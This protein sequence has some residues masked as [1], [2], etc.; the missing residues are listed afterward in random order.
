VATVGGQYGKGTVFKLTRTPAGTWHFE[1]LYAFKGTPDGA[2][3]YGALVFDVAGR[4]FGTAYYE[5]AHGYG[6]VF[7][8]A[9]TPSGQW[10]E[11]VIHSFAG[12]WQGGYPSGHLNLIDGELYGT[13]SEGGDDNCYCGTIFKL[14]DLGE[15]QWYHSVLHIF[16]GSP[17]G[18]SAYN[19]M[20]KG[21][22]GKLYGATVHGG[23]DDDGVVFKFTP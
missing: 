11:R 23:A 17:D 15:S 3:P 19:G 9:R 14:T 8:L 18:A 12:D 22:G 10:K 13:T 2:L 4:L 1:T 20:L 16:E 6:A 7:Q 5:G 21:P